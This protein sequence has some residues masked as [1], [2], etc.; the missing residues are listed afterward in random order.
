[1]GVPVDQE[2]VW[3]YVYT[4]H[5]K[6]SQASIGFIAQVNRDPR[7]NPQLDIVHPNIQYLKFIVGGKTSYY[8]GFNGQITKLVYRVG[9]GAFI[10][11]LDQFKAHLLNQGPFPSV[12]LEKTTNITVA[13][14]TPVDVVARQPEAY[15]LVTDDSTQFPH[16]YSVSGW[17]KFNGPFAGD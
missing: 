6:K 5:S 1:M 3:T 14:D 10:D 2:G 4:S 8:P 15:Q 12:I 13:G 11:T 7:R 9:D 16:E 17:F